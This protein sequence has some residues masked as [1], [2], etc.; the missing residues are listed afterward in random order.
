MAIENNIQ[1]IPIVIE[2][3]WEI[4]WDDGQ[5]LGSHPGVVHV[6]VFAPINTE[7]YDEKNASEL[8]NYVYNKMSSHWKLKNKL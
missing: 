6:Q 7:S 3:A 1:I 2:N 5:K 4:L 8:E